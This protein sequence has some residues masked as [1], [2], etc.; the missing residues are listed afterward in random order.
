[1]LSSQHKKILELQNQYL[2]RVSRNVLKLNNQL[3]LLIDLEDSMLGG[4]EDEATGLIAADISLA[5]AQHLQTETEKK[6]E[7]L[8][9]NLADLKD[10]IDGFSEKIKP[11]LEGQRDLAKDVSGIIKPEEIKGL[12]PEQLNQVQA[13]LKVKENEDKNVDEIW[14]I[15][16]KPE[17]SEEP[18]S[19]SQPKPEHKQIESTPQSNP[20]DQPTQQLRTESEP[21]SSEHKQGESISQSKPSAQSTQQSR[22]E[23]RSEP[24]PESGHE[25]TN[26]PVQSTPQSTQQSTSQP[27][28]KS[29]ARTPPR[30]N[31]K[32]KKIKRNKEDKS[33]K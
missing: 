29:D 5:I 20:S 4:A 31:K 21:K 7:A 1:M 23:T 13:A 14:N 18:S 2:D 27:S 26:P 6:V 9:T 8:N 10:T 24:K 28:S 33:K 32:T 16:K 12:S 30:Q 19:K 11:I 22:T 3:D 25:Q 15:I 17:S